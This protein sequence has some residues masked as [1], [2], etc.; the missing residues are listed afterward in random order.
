[1]AS[2]ERGPARLRAAAACVFVLM[3][4][5]DARALENQLGGVGCEVLR[6]LPLNLNVDWQTQVKPIINEQFMSGRCTSCHNAG[7][8][9]GNLDL[10]DEAIDAIYKIVPAGYVVPGRPLD[11]ILFDKVNCDEPG[12]GGVRMPFF[13]N[14]LTTEQQ[15]LIFDW[16]AQGALGDVEGE[17]PIPRDFVF[18]D[19]LESIRY[20]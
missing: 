13:Q 12:H 17:P 6:G 7:Q 1:M 11:S 19:G 16:I 4:C 9:D 5:G 20:Y 2:S 18:R 14:P 3:A 10:T 8:L 15:A